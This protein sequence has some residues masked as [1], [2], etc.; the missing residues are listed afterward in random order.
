MRFSDI[1]TFTRGAAYRVNIPLESVSRTLDD[2]IRESKLDMNPDFQRGHVWNTEQQIR[3]IEYLL[4]EGISSRE[5]SFN[6]AG[7]NSQREGPFV[8]VDGK[9]RL[10][11]VRLFMDGKIPAFGYYRHEYSD[12]AS[13]LNTLIFCVNDL[14]TRAEV[15]QWYLDLNDGGVVHS[16]EEIFRVRA[17]L[18]LEMEVPSEGSPRRKRRK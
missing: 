3:F 12:R 18:K 13:N 2:Y 16:Q 4:R 9:Q 5:I 1:K 10:E 15:L 17:M 14:P 11:A 8:L 6:C 7:W